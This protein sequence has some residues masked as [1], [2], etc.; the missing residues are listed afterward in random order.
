MKILSLF[1]QGIPK[2]KD[3]TCRKRKI[4]E[5]L[6]M[7]NKEAKRIQNRSKDFKKVHNLI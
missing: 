2:N 3:L 5:Q 7:L 6:C 1:F 4:C